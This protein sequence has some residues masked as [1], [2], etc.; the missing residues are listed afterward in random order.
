MCLADIHSNCFYNISYVYISGGPGFPL[1]NSHLS[2]VGIPNGGFAHGQ[3]AVVS[4]ASPFMGSTFSPP[5]AYTEGVPSFLSSTMR[6]TGGF[7]AFS[8]ETS[9]VGFTP[10][11]G[12]GFASG[13]Y[14]HDGLQFGSFAR[15]VALP[16]TTMSFTDGSGFGLDSSF[17]R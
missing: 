8:A 4:S 3:S 2:F 7:P 1:L 5:S 11:V 17:S 13:P 12:F 9:A 6:Y 16:Q 15:G 10:S 14:S